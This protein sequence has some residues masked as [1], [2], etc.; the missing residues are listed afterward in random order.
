MQC[1]I[2]H[3]TEDAHFTPLVESIKNF[4]YMSVFIV[5]CEYSAIWFFAV[6]LIVSDIFS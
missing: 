1:L 3:Y 4:V 5:Y 2:N 6:V